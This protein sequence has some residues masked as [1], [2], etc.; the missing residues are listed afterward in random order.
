MALGSAGLRAGRG[1]GVLC[2]GG[3]NEGAEQLGDSRK[4]LVCQRPSGAKHFCPICEGLLGRKRKGRKPD[5]GA[6]RDA[7]R[8]QWNIDLQAFTCK[9]TGIALTHNGGARNAE[10]EHP[11]PGD[12]SSVVLVAALVNRM[13]ADLTENQWD[14]MIRALY[15]LRIEGE[16]FNESALPL[17]WQVKA[18]SW[19]NGD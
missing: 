17:N 8:E 6:R 13:K 5:M 10:W 1:E 2:S 3:M 15:A 7:L 9:Y 4:C 14:A 16:P 12:E 11:T 19:R 18:T